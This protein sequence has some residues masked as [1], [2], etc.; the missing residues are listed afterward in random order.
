M[1]LIENLIYIPC[2][3]KSSR[4]PNKNILKFNKER[5]F[6]K[7]IKQ[8]KKIKLE[9]YILVDSDSDFILKSSKKLKVNI[10]KRKKKYTKKST[11]TSDCLIDVLNYYKKK[12]IYFKNIIKLQVTSPLRRESD[13]TSAYKIFKNK[14]AN[15]VIS[16]CKTFSPVQWANV[17]N[18]KKEI[19]NFISKE[20]MG[21]ISQKL[22]DHYQIYGAVYIF[23]T[24]IFL[25]NKK[26]LNLKKSFAYIMP[27]ASSVDI[28]DKFDF[29]LA[30]QI[31]K[32]NNYYL[33]K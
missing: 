16:L 27:R 28:D 26:Y 25:R 8:A 19:N 15:A 33:Y 2:K 10:Y 14:N 31:N 22:K 6:I 4:L 17:L 32:I 13:I 30:K 9:K 20:D 3:S 5:L 24:D 1:R 29:F 18:K 11:P 7:T 23:K 12:N 21:T